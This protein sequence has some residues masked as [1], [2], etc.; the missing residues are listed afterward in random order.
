MTNATVVLNSDPQTR[1][2]RL[3]SL[4]NPETK[5]DA[6]PSIYRLIW[7]LTSINQIGILILS[8]LVIPLTIVP[9]E[10]QRRIIDDA[11]GHRNVAGLV[12]LV[13]L[14]LGVVVA[15]AS[16]AYILNMQEGRVHEI[17]ARRLRQQ[18]AQLVRRR[19]L[20]EQTDVRGGTITSIFTSEVDPVGEFSGQAVSVPLVE[21]GVFLS[22]IGYMLFTNPVL[23]SVAISLFIPQIFLVAFVQTRINRRTRERIKTLRAC[24]EECLKI[25]DG[26][27]GSLFAFV[28]QSI[29]NVFGLRMQ[30]YHLKYSMKSIVLFSIF[31]VRAIILGFGGYLVINGQTEIGVIVA[32]LSGIDRLSGRWNDLLA[33]FRRMSDARIKYDL[34]R[35][36]LKSG[37]S[38]SII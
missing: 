16:F 26:R 14:Y 5:G 34:I 9:L 24:S 36:T 35:D 21:G 15:Q 38:A 3:R 1:S 10:L 6:P 22:V 8:L 18:L 13:S 32:F 33:F 27:P 28:P 11:I 7:R 29:R 19:N 30:I 31:V 12:T 23:A 2:G 4:F 17:V 25:F 20:R 37:K